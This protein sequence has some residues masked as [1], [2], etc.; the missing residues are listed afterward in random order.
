MLSSTGLHMLRSILGHACTS[1]FLIGCLL[2]PSALAAPVDV[3]V[4][5][6]QHVN[7]YAGTADT[8]LQQA[9]PSTKN[10]TAPRLRVDGDDP[11]GSGNVVQALLRFDNLFGPA[12]G[13]IPLVVEIERATLE[14]HLTD[15]AI[16]SV[17]LFRVL[18]TYSDEQGR[19]ESLDLQANGLPGIQAD[20]I[21]ATSIP[22]ATA[23]VVGTGA[24]SI[25]VTTG[26]LAW[27]A[28]PNSNHGWAL[29]PTG[30][31]GV[32]FY[33]AEGLVPPKLTV[34][35]SVPAPSG[36]AVGVCIGIVIWRRRRQ[37]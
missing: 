2:A 8:F 31:D 15:A 16:D 7:G 32:E 34:S 21:E 33:S 27:Q 28:D 20:D 12:R 37:P 9:S 19:W 14:L 1:G 4:T 36:V 24:L 6:Q 29:L 10:A 5:F 17:E 13:Q 18:V 35:F 30:P 23:T 25:D 22:D 26:L 3:S 11:P